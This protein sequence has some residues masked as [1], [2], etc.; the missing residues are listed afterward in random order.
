MATPI[1]ELC[2]EFVNRSAELDPIFATMRGI[3]GTP[4]GAATDFSPDG[5]AARHDLV[6][7]TLRRLDALTPTSDDD[8]L[9]AV[10]LRE[11]LQVEHDAHEIGEPFR[12]LRAPFG[13]LSSL[14]DSVD[15]MP[16]GDDEQWAHVAERLAAMPTMLGGW[17]ATLDVG[18]S[19]GLYAARRQAVEAAAQAR[20]YAGS[21]DARP[22][23]DPI[24]DGYGDGPLASQLRAGAEAAH[25]AYL[26]LARY[27]VDEYAPGAPET[28]GV[29]RERYVV[30]SRSALG[31][32]LDPVDSYEWGWD[33]LYRLEREIEAEQNAI[34]PGA[35]HA[36][37]VALLDDTSSVDSPEEYQRWLQEQH[38]AAIAR[39]DGVHFDL[40]PAL[41]TVNA[42]LA[43]GSSSG[44][45]YYTP[46]SEDLTRPGRTWWPVAARQRFGVW[47]ELTTVFHEGVPG[48]HLQLGAARVAG[49]RLSRYSRI[50]GVSGHGEGWALYAE[51]LADELG[52]FAEP[53]TRLGMLHGSALR[54]TRVIVDIGLHLDLPMPEREVE[55]YG[56]RW[57]FDVG[58][59]AL[60][61][62]GRLAPHRIHP[63]MVRYAGWP[64]QATAYK[65]GERAWVA[66]RDEAMARQGAA[67]DLKAW[68]SAALALGPIG[69]GGLAEMLRRAG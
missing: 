22:T 26:D 67:F 17:R 53:G 3:A 42:V 40:H 30:A 54:A 34:K 36:E 64:A 50:S 4:T 20:R 31:D 37:I 55:R 16:R 51:R 61:E 63:E 33:E 2:D 68:H 59:R 48:H 1:F 66:A 21:D 12:N 18:R 10:H 24:I 35:D 69:L 28:E 65:L 49:D 14:R 23:F 32:T 57:T 29:G 62:R 38:D 6:D 56:R 19:R 45:A 43:T 15:L 46:P 7:D 39:L 25:A 52:W 9:A 5:V 41:R 13:L 11:R 27:L 8:R 44:A 58:E 60:A 47:K